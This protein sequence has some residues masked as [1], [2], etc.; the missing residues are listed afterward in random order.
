MFADDHVT[1][2]RS[3]NKMS[4]ILQD[5]LALLGHNMLKGTTVMTSHSTN[6]NSPRS[7][8]VSCK[9]ESANIFGEL[10]G[11]QKS[12]DASEIFK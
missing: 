12:V 5:E 8:L 1:P 7:L 3:L 6:S 11:L 9:L 4:C 2:A 10:S